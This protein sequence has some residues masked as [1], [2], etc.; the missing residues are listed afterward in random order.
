M[1]RNK[2]SS[3]VVSKDKYFQYSDTETQD[4][5]DVSTNINLLASS[6]LKSKKCFFFSNENNYNI[7]F[8]KENNMFT[9]HD[10]NTRKETNFCLV[11]IFYFKENDSECYILQTNEHA[12]FIKVIL[13]ICPFTYKF[14]DIWQHEPDN[15][16][17]FEDMTRIHSVV[18]HLYQ[19]YFLKKDK[20]KTEWLLYCLERRNV[21]AP[22]LF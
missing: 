19:T 12:Q 17:S 21:S 8:G 20:D 16:T 4:D 9:H 13:Q 22:W 14:Y 3:L 11:N 5:D 7:S 1:Y 2:G 10:D 6:M 18:K 15:I